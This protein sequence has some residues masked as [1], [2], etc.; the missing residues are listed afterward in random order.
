ML[1]AA[2][3]A[4]VGVWNLFVIKVLAE[5]GQIKFICYAACCSCATRSLKSNTLNITFS[6]MKVGL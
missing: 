4:V 2:L 1:K 3:A 6:G 5:I